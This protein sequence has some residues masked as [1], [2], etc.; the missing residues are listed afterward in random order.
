[1]YT[2]QEIKERRKDALKKKREGYIALGLTIRG[3]PRVV[4]EKKEHS[5]EEIRARRVTYARN[6]REKNREKHLEYRKDYRERQKEVDREHRAKNLDAIREYQKVWAREYRAK[7][8][9]RLLVK[10]GCA[11]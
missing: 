7:K 11:A 2:E 5:I 10:S 6:Y 9:L 3:T 1:M 8:R 4:K